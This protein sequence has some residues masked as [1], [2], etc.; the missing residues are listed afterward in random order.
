MVT[1]GNWTLGGNHTMEYINVGED[2]EKKEPSYSASGTAD[3]YSHYGKQYG[4][5]SKT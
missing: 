5:S 3:W 1:K 4:G 2:A